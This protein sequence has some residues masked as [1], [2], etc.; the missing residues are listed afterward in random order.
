MLCAAK[1]CSLYYFIIP[2]LLTWRSG[3]PWI[4]AKNAFT[5]VVNKKWMTWRNI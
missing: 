1:D 5:S 4:R 2:R 3:Q